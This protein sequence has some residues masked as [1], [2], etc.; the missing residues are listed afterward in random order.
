MSE[1]EK[2]DIDKAISIIKEEQK[3]GWDNLDIW[4]DE[5]E[6]KKT[7]D[8]LSAVETLLAVQHDQQQEI[9]TL[10]SYKL[11]CDAAM[12][13]FK[14]LKDKATPKEVFYESDGYADGAPVYDMAKCPN[15]DNLFEDSD[16]DWE[17][18]YC[19]SCG[20]ALKWDV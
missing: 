17:V 6:K 8:Y 14:R 19:P 10:R 18:D 13:E 2:M 15:C 1:F 16:D 11:D 4:S 20:Q 9:N 5:D 7:I 12:E 3:L